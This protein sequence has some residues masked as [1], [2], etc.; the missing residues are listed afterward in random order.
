MAVNQLRRAVM[1][2]TVDS[3]M[4]ISTRVAVAVSQRWRFMPRCA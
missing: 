4:P 2:A 1:I 3:A